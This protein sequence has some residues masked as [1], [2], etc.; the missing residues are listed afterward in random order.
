MVPAQH[1]RAL[2]RRSRPMACARGF[3][4]HRPGAGIGGEHANVG[5]ASAA[6]LGKINAPPAVAAI[7]PGK[8]G[9]LL[10]QASPRAGG[11]TRLKAGA[12]RE[13]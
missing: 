13:R 1:Y 8:A 2:V 5:A 11:T 4:H 6:A 3:V 7:R 10:I 12:G 9:R